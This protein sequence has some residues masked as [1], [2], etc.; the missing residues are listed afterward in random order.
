M[1]T[2]SPRGAEHHRVADLD[3][4]RLLANPDRPG[5][6]PRAK[7]SGG[8]LRQ[9]LRASVPGARWRR[10]QLQRKGTADG[11]GF[12]PMF[13]QDSSDAVTVA[14][15]LACHYPTKKGNP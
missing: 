13:S 7:S 2:R 3:R 12:S 1:P 10:D 8:V 14:G 5:E 6:V 11:V 9:E 15:V 4:D